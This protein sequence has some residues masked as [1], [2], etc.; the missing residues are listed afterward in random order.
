[1]HSTIAGQWRRKGSHMRKLIRGLTPPLL[2]KLVE[3]LRVRWEARPEWE[4]IPEGWPYAQTHPEVKGWDVQAIVDVYRSKWPRFLQLIEGSA[5]L[6]VDHQSPLTANTNVTSHNLNMTFAY[7]LALA[8]HR[9]G[10]IRMLDWG[11]GIGHYYLLARSLMPEVDIEYSCRDLPLLCSYGAELFPDQQFFADDRWRS[12]SYDLVMSSGSLQFAEDWR[13]LLQGLCAVT[14]DLLYVTNL[15][16]VRK[17]PSF[18]F[19]QR[20]YRRGY[21]T[22]YLGW[23]INEQELLQEIDAAGLTLRREFVLHIKPVI[24]GAPEQNTYRGY[25]FQRRQALG[26]SLAGS[27]PPPQV[28]A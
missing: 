28:L 18:V 12:R 22:E 15:P 20:P 13:K 16:I 5:P 4:Y 7:V 11:G 8:A 2:A 23:C 26:D 1:M 3:T 21:D 27:K 25:L 17:S 24:R 14:Q 9:N 6:G 19:I 10:R